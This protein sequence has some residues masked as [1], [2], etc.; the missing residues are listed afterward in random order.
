[1]KK[2]YFTESILNYLQL[3]NRYTKK[4]EVYNLLKSKLQFDIKAKMYKLTP[5]LQN[6]LDFHETNKID[7][8]CLFEILDNVIIKEDI[9][10]DTNPIHFEL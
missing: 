5:E 4:V 7:N 2:Y 8:F 3:K 6:I 1:M 9:V 10:V